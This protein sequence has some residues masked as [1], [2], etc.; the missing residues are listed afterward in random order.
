L[1]TEIELFEA[2]GLTSLDFCLWGWMKWEV[3]KR[4]VD[5]PDELLARIMDAA[6]RIKRSEDQLRRTTRDLR[7]RIAKRTEAD[8]GIFER[9]L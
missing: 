4:K 3:D 2:A 9:L 8:G 5:T 1:V 7:T 6:A